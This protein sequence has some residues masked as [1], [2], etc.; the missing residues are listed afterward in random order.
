MDDLA[1]ALWENIQQALEPFYDSHLCLYVTSECFGD[2]PKIPDI[3]NYATGCILNDGK[4]VPMEED[5][6]AALLLVTRKPEN[7][8]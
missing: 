2:D 3:Y 7:V 8:A 6:N 1:V 4:W 5:G